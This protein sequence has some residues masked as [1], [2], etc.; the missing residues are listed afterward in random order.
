MK[1]SILL[2]SA[3]ALVAVSGAQAA[4][5]P[6]VE[7]VDYVR[8]C[9]AFGAG[10][11]Y[12]PGT[13]TCL[14]FSGR[15]RTEIGVRSNDDDGDDDDTVDTSFLNSNFELVVN[16]SSM[17]EVGM[18][19]GQFAIAGSNEGSVSIGDAWITIGENILVGREVSRYDFGGGYGIYDGLY[20]DEGINQFTFIMPFGN[21]LS[22]TLGLEDGRDRRAKIA[23][24]AGT[25]ISANISYTVPT[26]VSA[27]G[28]ITGNLTVST[29]TTFSAG[30]NVGVDATYAGMEIPDVVASLRISQGWGSAQISGALHQIRSLTVAPTLT[31]PFTAS[32]LLTPTAVAAA[33]TLDEDY[34]YA[35]QAGVELNVGSMT[36]V[37]V[38]GAYADGA[39]HYIGGADYYEAAVDVV[40]GNIT[41]TL[42]GWYVLAGLSHDFS[43]DLNLGLTGA[44]HDFDDQAEL[45]MVSATLEY[46]VVENLVVSLAGQYTDTE[47]EANTA[48]GTVA[49]DTENWEAKLRIQRNF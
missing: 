23:Q 14:K 11:H 46:E 45:W 9:D 40:T 35:I 8:V 18:L 48:L 34:G 30:S 2:G 31:G 38:V 44:Y 1:K 5:L 43:S 39:M 13:E 16:A 27:S 47:N 36:K 28:A 22:M 3:A 29:T 4:D 21:G 24:Y 33:G 25:T 6:V 41:D 42:D 19:V 32:S 37:K 26:A 49:S 10:F 15:V 7:P 17:T 20:V 12:I